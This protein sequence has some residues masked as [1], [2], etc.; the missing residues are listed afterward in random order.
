MSRASEG[1]DPTFP[2]W[3]EHDCLETSNSHRSLR[4]KSNLAVLDPNGLTVLAEP[5]Y[6]PP[7]ARGG[8]GG[9]IR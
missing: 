1:E 3:P 2:R 6:G 8:D 7:R 9:T 5:G 4:Y